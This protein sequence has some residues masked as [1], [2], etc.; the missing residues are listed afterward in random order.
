MKYIST[1]GFE[2]KFTAQE[3][4]IKGIAPDGGLFVPESIPVLT[5]D[6]IAQTNDQPVAGNG[7]ENAAGNPNE[8]AQN[9]HAENCN[10]HTDKAV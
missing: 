10:R 9:I 6:D 7:N 1:R 8:R 2:G 3:A 5:E 4:I